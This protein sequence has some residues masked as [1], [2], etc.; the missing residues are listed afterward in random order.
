MP[1]GTLKVDLGHCNLG[2]DNINS[3]AKLLSAY[4][5]RFSYLN[6]SD[7]DI[8]G[9]GIETF[10]HAV[11]KY[12]FL[13][14]PVDIDLSYNQL[15]TRVGYLTAIPGVRELSV[16]HNHLGDAAGRFR[17]SNIESLDI[18]FNEAGDDAITQDAYTTSIKKLNAASNNIGELGALR[19]GVLNHTITDLN[20][21][22]NHIGSN[23]MIGLTN[24]KT[25]RVLNLSNN[26][27]DDAGL[28]NID[29]FPYTEITLDD[30]QV[31]NV[32]ARYLSLSPTLTRISLANNQVGA[33]GAIAFSLDM[34]ITDLDLANNNL[35]DTGAMALATH[36]FNIL[37]V[38]HNNLSV[39]GLGALDEAK[40]RGDIKVL[41]E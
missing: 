29:K 12:P 27:I 30:N 37:N 33:L 4:S 40:I 9:S 2:D 7:N 13:A 15:G 22:N 24:N 8:S 41:V 39:M 3:M 25:L 19:I 18:S 10:Y 23:G 16:A 14:N 35:S 26:G 21:A 31:T 38:A 32:G 11:F 20:L 28:K 34:Y 17:Y 36:H 6:L 1:G 5:R